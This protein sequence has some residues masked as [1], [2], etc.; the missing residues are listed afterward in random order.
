MTSYTPRIFSCR[1]DISSAAYFIGAALLVPGSEV[2]IQNV[3]INDTRA[4]ILKVCKSMGA[5]I[6]YMNQKDGAGE[7]TADLLVRHSSL[8]GTC[9]EGFHHPNAHR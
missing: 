1:E 4:G 9:I 5:D 8:T 6:T 7:P 3:G 2:L